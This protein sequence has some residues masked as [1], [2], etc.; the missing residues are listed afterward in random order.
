[1]V[2]SGV[3]KLIRNIS[4]NN[5]KAVELP[6]LG[7]FGPFVTKFQRLRDPLD[8]G[9]AGNQ[10]PRPEDLGIKPIRFLVNDEFLTCTG[11]NVA[12]DTHSQNSAGRYGKDDRSQID[13]AFQN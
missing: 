8:K 2:W 12:V 13:D 4:L 5:Q 9:D 7:I 6:G 11:W 1:M 10:K 3:T